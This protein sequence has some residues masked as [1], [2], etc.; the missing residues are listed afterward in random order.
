MG[1]YCVT[2]SKLKRYEQNDCCNVTTQA[3]L[4]LNRKGGL[5]GDRAATQPTES[6]KG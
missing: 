6:L 1:I 3:A 5:G 4:Q 2:A